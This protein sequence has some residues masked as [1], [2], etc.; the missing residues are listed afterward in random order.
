MLKQ[1]EEH[2]GKSVIHFSEIKIFQNLNHFDK[3][4]A[5]IAK[6]IKIEGFEF[7][8][9][10]TVVLPHCVKQGRNKNITVANHVIGLKCQHVPV[11]Q[12]I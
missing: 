11:P 4:L 12:L 10:C 5:K 7:P 9:N 3:V 1:A 2:W 8:E 6:V